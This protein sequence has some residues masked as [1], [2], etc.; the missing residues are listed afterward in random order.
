T[1][2][3]V[4]RLHMEIFGTYYA[5]AFKN[6]WSDNWLTD[7]Y[8]PE[9]LRRWPIHVVD[10][11]GGTERYAVDRQ[12]ASVLETAVSRGRERLER[13]LATRPRDGATPG[14]RVIAF[15]L[16]GREPRYLVG[17]VRNAELAARVY[18]GW[19]CRFYVGRSVPSATVRRLAALPNTELIG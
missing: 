19:T 2:S 7:V 13:C 5:T 3:F 12:A 16:W 8:A 15:S 11:R 18:P 9:H 6:W 17:A 1:Q 14:K 10:N 4:S